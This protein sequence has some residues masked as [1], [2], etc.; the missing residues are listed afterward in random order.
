M[1]AVLQP[2]IFRIFPDGFGPI[3]AEKH[4]ELTGIYRKKS[5]KFSVGILLPPFPAISGAFF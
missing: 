5:K 2:E 4:K 1:E 3:P